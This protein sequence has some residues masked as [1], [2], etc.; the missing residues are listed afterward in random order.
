VQIPADLA[1]TY[2]KGNPTNHSEEQFMRFLSLAFIASMLA[3][4]AC[5]STKKPSDSNFRKTINQYLAKHGEACTMIGREFPVDVTE[6]EQ[7][8]QSDTATQMAVL[9]QAGLLRSSNTTAVVH[10]MLDALQDSTRP[11]PVK[12][13]KLTAE[14]QKY[15]HKTRGIFGQM[16]SFCYGEKT[17]DSIVKW[18]EPATIGAATQTEVTYTYKIADLAPWA[19]R[20]D[21]QREFGDVRATVSGISKSNEIVGLQLTNQGWEVPTP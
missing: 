16:A 9:E 19:E 14:G 4:S 2:C 15:F 12:R 10:G 1:G 8:L 7:R 5:N 3:L 13:Y 18:T 6:A 11:Q 21:V 20:P 17:V